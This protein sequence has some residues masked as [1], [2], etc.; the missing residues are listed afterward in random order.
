MRLGDGQ[1]SNSNV[2]TSAESLN[3]STKSEVQPLPGWVGETIAS[4]DLPKKSN[5]PTN[6]S[7]FANPSGS[8]TASGAKYFDNVASMLAGV[9]DALQHAHD[10]GI[11]HRDIKPSNLLLA[12][13]GRLSITDF[14]LARVLEQPGMTMSGE[15]VGTP[16]CMSPEQITAGR[17]QFDHRTD[18]YSLGATLYEM[19]TLQPPFPGRS[20][21]EVIGQILHKEPKPPR[22]VKRSIPADL[23]TICLKA[24]ERDPDKRYQS[25]GQMA[26]GMRAFVNRF[27]ISARRIGPVGK[28]IKWAKRHPTVVAMIL[29][30]ISSIAVLVG[31]HYSNKREQLASAQKRAIEYAMSGKHEKATEQLK[32]ADRLGATR[33]WLLFHEAEIEIYRGR[34][35][36]ARSLLEQLLE[37]NQ[38]PAVQCLTSPTR[39]ASS[40]ARRANHIFVSFSARKWRVLAHKSPGCRDRQPGNP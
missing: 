37:G 16:L 9:A 11:I 21:D 10:H 13:D 3:E 25:A 35:G 28:T 6:S 14:G 12:P 23:E 33:E 32:L 34:H 30:T 4:E 19:L 17:A 31:Q 2:D 20:R 40:L 36:K 1:E 29:V 22:R 8:S 18:I 27:A 24:V 39:V 38:S 15:I 5:P 7:S 26:E